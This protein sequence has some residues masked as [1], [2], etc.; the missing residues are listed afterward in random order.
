MSAFNSPGLL[1]FSFLSSSHPRTTNRSFGTLCHGL[2]FVHDIDLCHHCFFMCCSFG[3]LLHQC[4]WMSFLAFHCANVTFTCHVL[5]CDS[6][7][8]CIHCIHLQLSL[9]FLFLIRFC[10]LAN[11]ALVRLRHFISSHHCRISCIY[12]W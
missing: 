8:C 10:I 5:F 2:S 12:R 4:H 1:I 11:Q 9:F 3:I 6:C 7:L